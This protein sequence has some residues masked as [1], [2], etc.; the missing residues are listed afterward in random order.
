MQV[1]AGERA[2]TIRVTYQEATELRN[3]LM[4]AGYNYQWATRSVTGCYELYERLVKALAD[5][6][7]KGRPLPP[8]PKNEVAHNSPVT[9]VEEARYLLIEF[10]C[11]VERFGVHFQLLEVV[12]QVAT[13]D[14]QYAPVA[15]RLEVAG[16][17]VVVAGV[18]RPVH[19]EL[20]GGDIGIWEHLHQD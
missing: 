13:A 20:V 3:V 14:D 15:Q 7:A 1:I 4:D 16:E 2:V 17:F 19:A 6:K 18:L 11:P 9:I 10:N 8:L 12:D 5:G